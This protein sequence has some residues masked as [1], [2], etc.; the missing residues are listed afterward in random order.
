MENVTFWK[1]RR[2]IRSAHCSSINVPLV[3]MPESG[4]HEEF[5][6]LEAEC[7]QI[8]I[9]PDEL[10]AQLLPD[11]GRTEQVIAILGLIAMNAAD[12]AAIA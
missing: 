2:T 10:A 1:G 7:G 8:G 4:D 6:A 9:K 3:L 5:A 11:F 12:I